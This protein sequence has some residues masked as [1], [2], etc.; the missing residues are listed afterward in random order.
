MLALALPVEHGTARK[1]VSILVDSEEERE[2]RGWRGERANETVEVGLRVT[3]ECSVGGAGYK[4]ALPLLPLLDP[5]SVNLKRE[6]EEE[7]EEGSIN[8]KPGEFLDR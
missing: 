1:T 5:L 3:Q 7:G 6:R 2:L 8:F 4:K